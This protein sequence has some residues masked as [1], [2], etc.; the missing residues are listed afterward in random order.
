MTG[1]LQVVPVGEL[2]QAWPQF[3]CEALAGTS[4]EFKS[5]EM[6]SGPHD[7]F[8]LINRAPRAYEFPSW[9]AYCPTRISLSLGLGSPGESDCS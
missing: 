5:A 8:G 4:F 2:G 6:L 9:Q 7:L 1:P 3:E